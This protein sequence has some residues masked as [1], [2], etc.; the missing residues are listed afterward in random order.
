MRLL[1][2][3]VEPLVFVSQPM[4][5]AG[6]HS[7]SYSISSTRVR[8][9][10]SQHHGLSPLSSLVRCVY[11]F[12]IKW[13]GYLIM[14]PF[15]II[16]FYERSRKCRLYVCFMGYWSSSQAQNHLAS[17]QKPASCCI[18]AHCRSCI[19]MCVFQSNGGVLHTRGRFIIGLD[20]IKLLD[21]FG[22]KNTDMF[23]NV[24]P[25][26][27]IY[28]QVK[29]AEPVMSVVFAQAIL[30]ETYP[31]Y[32]W[33]SLVPIIAGCSLAA[34]KEVSFS[35]GGFNNAMISNIG[36]VLRNIYSKKLLSDFKVIGFYCL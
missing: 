27:K 26:Q 31:Y 19:C 5:L 34:M 1:Q 33:L 6:M 2:A 29:A 11:L 4:C 36:M 28:I 3:T 8:W 25:I 10:S 12:V 13:T 35:W 17:R 30:G 15:L 9:M 16:V 18:L 20:D 21:L 22:R 24:S 23:L 32:V 7:T 14:Y